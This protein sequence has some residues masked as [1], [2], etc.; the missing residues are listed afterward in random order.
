MLQDMDASDHFFGSYDEARLHAPEHM[1]PKIK[2]FSEQSVPRIEAMFDKIADIARAQM[3]QH[4]QHL[5]CSG[6]I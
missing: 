4:A 1:D 5:D 6:S 3:R 2:R